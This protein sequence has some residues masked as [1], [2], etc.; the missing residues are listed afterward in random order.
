MLNK[1]QLIKEPELNTVRHV[2]KERTK[3]NRDRARTALQVVSSQYKKVK[4]AFVNSAIK[5]E[6][7][8]KAR[9]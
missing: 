2:R 3:Q 4:M 7:L 8:N 5:E 9:V 1:K 6:A